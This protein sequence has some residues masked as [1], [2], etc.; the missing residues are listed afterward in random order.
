MSRFRQ[1]RSKKELDDLISAVTKDKKKIKEEIDDTVVGKEF[2]KQQNAVSQAPVLAGLEGVAKRI[3]E[4]FNPAVTE[5][6]VGGKPELGTRIKKTPGGDIVRINKI[7]QLLVDN[8][9]LSNEIKKAVTENKDK[10]VEGLQLN[11]AKLS[12]LVGIAAMSQSSLTQTAT[13]TAALEKILNDNFK[14][15]TD[16]LSRM[17]P[18]LAKITIDSIGSTINITELEKQKAKIE[19]KLKLQTQSDLEKA[20]LQK[21]LDE[22]EKQKAEILAKM[23]AQADA[24]KLPPPP[25]PDASSGSTSSTPSKSPIVPDFDGDIFDLPDEPFY[26]P[27]PTPVTTKFGSPSTPSSP[28]HAAPTTTAGTSTVSSTT[29]STI[30]PNLGS[31]EDVENEKEKEQ[32]KVSK[33]AATDAADADLDN[34]FDVEFEQ[35]LNEIQSVKEDEQSKPKSITLKILEDE[36]ERIEKEEAAQPINENEIKS[37]IGTKN[38]DLIAKAIGKINRLSYLED[39]NDILNSAKILGHDTSNIPEMKNLDI[40]SEENK[41]F[42]FGVSKLQTQILRDLM[43]DAFRIDPKKAAKK[44]NIQS[45][46]LNYDYAPNLNSNKISKKQQEI[47]E[48]YFTEMASSLKTIEQQNIDKINEFL[49][50][51]RAPSKDATR[52]DQKIYQI[53]TKLLNIP[54]FKSPVRASRTTSQKITDFRNDVINEITKLMKDPIK[55]Q[56]LLKKIAEYKVETVKSPKEKSASKSTKSS[57]PS[58]SSSSSSSSKPGQKATGILGVSIKYPSGY[59]PYRMT[60]TGAFGKLQISTKDLDNNHLRVYKDGKQIAYQPIEQ[61]LKDLLTK[62]FSKLKN[63]NPESV[64]VFQKLVKHGEIP[65]YDKL[66]KYQT[67]LKDFYEKEILPHLPMQQGQGCECEDYDSEEENEEPVTSKKGS[68]VKIFKDVD[69]VANRLQILIGEMSAGNDSESVLDEAS[70]LIN[71]LKK[72]NHIGDEDEKL[73]MKASGLI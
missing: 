49:A 7:Q 21:Q 52:I 31:A 37:L 69:D 23:K 60:G 33:D 4:I 28:Y 6:L 48:K 50:E 15:V 65:A 14:N 3:E 17:P 8:T 29:V 1:V 64:A 70:E 26:S 71:F 63:Y 41:P 40:L 47:R 67:L 19:A 43:K 12:R 53:G 27:E 22:A 38:I 11:D 9:A 72:G 13:A 55:N 24:S 44:R 56:D 57:A 10:V 20:E 68:R 73:L 2:S 58:K 32:E 61:D 39:Y 59:D 34:F 5:E 18:E 30:T 66:S 51:I 54:A 35:A 36:E 25:P 45:V 62:R 16:T 46:A 42:A